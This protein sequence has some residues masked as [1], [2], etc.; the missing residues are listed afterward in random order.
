MSLIARI[1]AEPELVAAPP[2]LVDV[3][4]AG[5]MHR[6]WRPI[7]RHAVGVGFE[8]DAREAAALTG[9]QRQFRRW[10]FCPALAAPVTPPDGQL[11]FHFTSSPQCSSM[12]PPDQ[13]GLREWVFADQFDVVRT[14][15]VP[16]AS[17]TESLQSAGVDHIDWLKCD[18]QGMD[19]KLYRSLPA[20]WRQQL[21]VAEFEP[22]F[23]DSYQGEDHV[24]DVLAAMK[25]EP[26]WLAGFSPGL[27]PRGRRDLMAA[28]WPS[29]IGPWL[30]RLAP[31]A[32][33]WAG[34]Q[35]IRDVGRVPEI[36]GRRGWLLAWVFAVVA[37]QP[38]YALT[39]ADEGR[40]RFGDVLFGEMEQESRRLLRCAMVRRLPGWLWCRLFR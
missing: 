8:P 1:F 35:F 39:I 21:L 15:A 5:G 40:R 16:A 33:A 36:T 32:P 22:G 17:L 10:V 18:T 24:A 20:A 2:V 6:V 38:G 30:R 9:A 3:G 27:T 7:A 26:F 19:L 12:L 14:A 11:P 4:A 28:G 13:A 23:I 31:L 25:A 37:R 34:L 29:A